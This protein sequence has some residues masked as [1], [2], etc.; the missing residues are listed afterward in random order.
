M[1]SVASYV[2]PSDSELMIMMI[3][4]SEFL[5][6]MNHMVC[7]L[8]NA[9]KFNENNKLFSNYPVM[10]IIGECPGNLLEKWLGCSEVSVLLV[11]SIFPDLHRENCVIFCERDGQTY[12]HEIG[13]HNS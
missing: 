9:L 8:K 4:H 6:T 1:T 13:V 5:T 12:S 2:T 11:T 10:I 3:H 7:H